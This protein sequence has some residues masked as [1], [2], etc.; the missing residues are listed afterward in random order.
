M[1]LPDRTI[2]MFEVP[3]EEVTARKRGGGTF[4]GF[5]MKNHPHQIA[6]RGGEV[7]DDTDT[8]I[9]PDAVFLP[10]HER[11]RFTIDVAAS[12]ANRR[13]ERYYDREANG[14]AQSWAGERAWCNPP[15]SDLLSWTKKAFEEV[16]HNGCELVV[17]LFPSNRTEQPF[18]QDYI[19]PYRETEFCRTRFLRSR[20]TFGTRDNPTGLYA[21]SP[22]FGIV[23]VTFSAPMTFDDRPIGPDAVLPGQVPMFRNGR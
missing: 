10:L 17:L 7:D 19:E 16:R 15:F 3:A 8:R 9:T 12:A 5:H 6:A 14:L 1:S 20:R 11:H 13:C 21:G 2:P 18:W 4:Q 22:P 23:L